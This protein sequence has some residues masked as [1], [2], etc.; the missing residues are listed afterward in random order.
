MVIKPRNKLCDFSLYLQNKTGSLYYTLQED[1]K[2]LNI[3]FYIKTACLLNDGH[4]FLCQQIDFELN[5][6][7]YMI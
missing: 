2:Y 3:K 6:F 5:E 4:Y 1:L 7:F